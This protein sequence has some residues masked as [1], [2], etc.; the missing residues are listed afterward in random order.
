MTW[1]VVL[2]LKEPTEYFVAISTELDRPVQAKGPQVVLVP[3]RQSAK[4]T[5]PFQHPI[6]VLT[7]DRRTFQP[8][9]RMEKAHPVRY[10]HSRFLRVERFRPLQQLRHN[11]LRI[12]DQVGMRH[13]E[14]TR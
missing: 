2:A 4:H 10:P 3:R 14:H 1:H 13:V 9:H 6:K 8:P 5:G 7:G 12:E 11:G